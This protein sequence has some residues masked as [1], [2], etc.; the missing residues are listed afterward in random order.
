[1]PDIT[2]CVARNCPKRLRCYRYTATPSGRGQSWVDYS[3]KGMVECE[4]FWDNLDK[5]AKVVFTGQ[6]N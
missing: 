5:G 4:D 3:K 2:M 1:M 6:K